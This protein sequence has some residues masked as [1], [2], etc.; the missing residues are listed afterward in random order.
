MHYVAIR[1]R[2]DL[3]GKPMKPDYVG[4]DDDDRMAVWACTTHAG[5]LWWAHERIDRYG[6]ETVMC[7]YEAHLDEATVEPDP[8]Y[9]LMESSVMAASGRLGQLLGS[10]ASRDEVRT[11]LDQRKGED[12]FVDDMLS[13]R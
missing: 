1:N 3:A 6:V 7:I 8:N 9:Q 13:R 4:G 5:A 10:F 2:A 11:A 12:P